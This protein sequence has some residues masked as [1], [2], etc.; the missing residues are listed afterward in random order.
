MKVQLEFGS[1]PP[2]LRLQLCEGV[3]VAA[4]PILGILTAE[5]GEVP[6]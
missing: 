3:G 2:C 5:H 1:T 6:S 4:G